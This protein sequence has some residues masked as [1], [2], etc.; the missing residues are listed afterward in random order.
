MALPGESVATQISSAGVS[1]YDDLTHRP[2]LVYEIA[3]LEARLDEGL[4]GLPLNY[5]I[6]TRAKVIKQ[7]IAEVLGY[8]A[9]SSFAKTR[10][11]FPGQD[12][13]VFV[14][15][16]GNLQIWNEE[17]TPTRRYALIRVDERETVSA[18]RVLTGE[19]I[20]LF[21]RTGTLTSKYQAKR[22][23]GR[24]GSAL[25]TPLDTEPF[26]LTFAAQVITPGSTLAGLSP[27]APP[28]PGQVLPIATAYSRLL[29]LV[30]HLFTDPGLLQE[31]ARG[32]EF[33]RLCCS[34]LGLGPYADIGQFPDI[35]SQAL[36]VK[37]QLSPTID[38]GL[39]APDSA[40]IAQEAGYGLRHCDV[41]YAVAY[42]SRVG[43]GEVRIESVVVTTGEAFFSEF[44]RFEGLVQN[45]KR[46]IPLPRGLFEAKR[47][48][49]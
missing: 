5:P 42:G 31:R 46:Q 23:P 8:R 22:R 35:L 6:R 14:Q 49:D 32:V 41:R 47:A 36:E 44:Q 4:R 48:P 30:G 16:S 33:Q 7:A 34:A 28:V 39:V 37:L 1:I 12:M 18:V 29:T 3:V 40:T 38:L 24:T 2:T 43:E 21:D 9:P 19:A 25:I 13:D 20:A 27:V 26:Q 17:I 15:K 45:T 10:P 11:R